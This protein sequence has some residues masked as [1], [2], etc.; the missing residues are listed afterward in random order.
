MLKIRVEDEVQ[1]ILCQESVKECFGFRIWTKA[2]WFFR[3]LFGS[4]PWV[5]YSCA[6]LFG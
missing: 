4:A 3:Q 5:S 2:K 6:E 1:T